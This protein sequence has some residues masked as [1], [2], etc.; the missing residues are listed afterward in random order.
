MTNLNFQK[1]GGLIPAII[2]NNTTMQVLM[3]GYMNPKALELTEKTG[4]VY[5]W[6]RG[7]KRIWMKGEKSGNILKVISI[8]DDCDS[9]TLL[10]KVNPMGPT[11][12]TNNVS[13]FSDSFL[14]E[15][16]NIILQ[17]KI[18]M[19][20]NS[21]TSSLFREGTDKITDKILEE[22]AEVVQ[23]A[24]KETD[25]RLIEESADLIYHLLVLLISKNIML[26]NVISELK[27]RIK[28]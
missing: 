5:F 11:C 24:Q 27:S 16:E 25:Q 7:K 18:M 20:K 23:A 17:R 15:L 13:C 4:K 26:K 1:S 14:G 28:R 3:L 10:I 6:S 9:D 21:Y 12:H 22:S 8:T 19:P 2:Q